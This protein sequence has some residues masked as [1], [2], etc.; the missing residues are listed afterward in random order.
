MG[1]SS[2]PFLSFPTGLPWNFVVIRAYVAVT[3]MGI[4]FLLR[5]HVDAEFIIWSMPVPSHK[6]RDGLSQCHRLSQ[7]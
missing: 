3:R 1:V 7:K 4:G 2:E 5:C 6:P